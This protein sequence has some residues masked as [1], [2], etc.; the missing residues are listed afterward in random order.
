MQLTNYMIWPIENLLNFLFVPVQSRAVLDQVVGFFWGIYLAWVAGRRKR[1]LTAAQLA[2]SPGRQSVTPSPKSAGEPN[3]ASDPSTVKCAASAPPHDPDTDTASPDSA[4]RSEDPSPG[5]APR[6][7][8]D[9]A[10]P[11]QGSP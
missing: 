10:S 7:G 8:L 1:T 4:P 3:T 2:D 5:T 9:A 6:P 11:G